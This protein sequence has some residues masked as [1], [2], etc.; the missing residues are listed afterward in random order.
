MRV[1]ML[2]GTPA[3]VPIVLWCSSRVI[4]LLLGHSYT[5][6]PI[7]LLWLDTRGIGRVFSVSPL[8]NIPQGTVKGTH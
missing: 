6:Q 5:L 2:M 7:V 1:Q 3:G 4:C 8:C